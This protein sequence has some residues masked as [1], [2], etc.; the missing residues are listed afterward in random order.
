MEKK[1]LAKEFVLVS[2]KFG[3]KGKDIRFKAVITD[4]ILPSNE[5]EECIGGRRTVFKF[6]D[7]VMN[8]YD[9]IDIPSMTVTDKGRLIWWDAIQPKDNEDYGK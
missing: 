1:E 6:K 9:V 8:V 5:A 7:T 3:L 4:D 2:K